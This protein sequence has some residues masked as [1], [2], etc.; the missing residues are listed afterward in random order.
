MNS[1]IA[2]AA[3]ALVVTATGIGAAHAEY[4]CNPPPTR[5]DRHACQAAAEGPQALRHY[6]QRMQMITNLRFSDY[7]NK[8]TVDAWETAKRD[9]AMGI[10]AEADSRSPKVTDTVPA[11]SAAEASRHATATR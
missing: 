11:T 9:S 1:T 10:S 4:R 8:A 6:V 7:V 5:I 3:A 2:R